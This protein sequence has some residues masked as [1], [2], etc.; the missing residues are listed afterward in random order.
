MCV[1]FFQLSKYDI[2]PSNILL[3]NFKHILKKFL[4]AILT[5]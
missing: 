5:Y 4:Q 2:L 1:H 3:I